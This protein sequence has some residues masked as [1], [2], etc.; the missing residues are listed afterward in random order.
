MVMPRP[1]LGLAL[2][3]LALVGCSET[4]ARTQLMLVAD[5]NIP[6]LNAIQFEVSDDGRTESAEATTLDAGPA[7]LAVVPTGDE[8]G[9][10]RVTA[11]GVRSNV[12]VVE[13]S[14][15]VS[16]VPHQTRVVELHLL[17]SCIVNECGSDESCTEQGCQPEALSEDEL[18]PWSGEAPQLDPP[19]PGGDAGAD[20]GTSSDAGRVDCGPGASGVDLETDVNHCGTCMNVCRP[21]GRNTQPVCSMGDCGVECRPLW[22]DCDGNAVNGCEQS[23]TVDD[24][25]GMCD[26]PCA[27][28]ATCVQGM[29][30]AR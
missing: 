29:C 16:F 23:L 2:A 28:D 27:S 13:R 11:Y 21:M 25:C 1:G 3:A 10:L 6:N 15:V 7:T 18:P 9:P 24:N 14:A 20:A 5:T 19:T 30:R 26:V 12:R 4:K 8:L 17:A 22:E